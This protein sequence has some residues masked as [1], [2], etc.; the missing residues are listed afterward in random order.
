MERQTSKKLK[1]IRT[2]NGSEYSGP[3]DIYCR[4]QGIRHQKTLS[5]TLQLNGLAERMDKILVERVRCLLLHTQL[6]QSF[7][8]EA[9]Y[10]IVHVLNL[11]QCLSFKFDVLDKVWYNRV[12]SYDYLHIFGCKDFIH[13]PKDKKSKP[14]RKTR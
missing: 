10:T 13:I 12:V 2:N 5:K 9:L 1:C 6:S 11:I 14:D 8:V 3:F 4:Q 7:W